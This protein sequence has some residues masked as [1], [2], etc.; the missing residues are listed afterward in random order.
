M[1]SVISS[2]TAKREGTRPNNVESVILWNW[3]GGTVD[4]SDFFTRYRF[5]KLRHLK[6]TRCAISSWNHLTSRTG[7]LTVLSLNFPSP[8]PTM[9]QLLSIIASNPLLQDVTLSSQAIPQN[10]GSPPSARVPLHNLKKLELAGGLR[11]VFRLLHQLDHPI[12]MDSLRL[13]LDN[14]KVAEISQIIG[15]HLRGYLRDRGRSRHELGLLISPGNSIILHVDGE[16]RT[17]WPLVRIDTFLLIMVRLDRSHRNE[18]ERATLDLIAH[19]PGEDIVHF[20]TFGSLVTTEN[21]CSWFPNLRTITFERARLQTIF[22][23]PDQGRDED[24][25]LSLQR[26]CFRGL[27]VDHG[28]WRPLITFLACRISSGNRLDTLEVC[29]RHPMSREVIE[30]VRGMVRELIVKESGPPDVAATDT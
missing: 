28:N 17:D 5:P 19:I 6:L 24:T 10:D 11:D 20:E 12:R 16:R 4:M 8:T 22:P 26:M 21:I 1:S 14:C 29:H 7:A 25:L 27:V 13:T 2:L 15:P 30:V 9:S 3:G 23:E 18:G